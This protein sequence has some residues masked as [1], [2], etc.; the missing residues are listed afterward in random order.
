MYQEI[1]S[2]KTSGEHLLLM[3]LPRFS[4]PAGIFKSEQ[5]IGVKTNPKRNQPY[6][7]GFIPQN[8]VLFYIFNLQSAVFINPYI[9]GFIP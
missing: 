8:Y 4:N 7:Y 9:Y 1:Q 3:P 5:M 2:T 6:I